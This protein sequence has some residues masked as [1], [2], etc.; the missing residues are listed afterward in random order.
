MARP[1]RPTMARRLCAAHG[2]PADRGQVVTI[3]SC[4]AGHPTTADQR[5]P[6]HAA[7]D[8]ARPPAGRL[9]GRRDRWLPRRRTRRATTHHRCGR[10]QR[11]R[12]D[13]VAA[14]SVRRIVGTDVGGEPR[15]QRQPGGVPGPSR[16]GDGSGRTGPMRVWF[17]VWRVDTDE[18]INATLDQLAAEHPNLHVVPWHDISAAASGVVQRHRRAPVH[19][20]LCRARSAGC[21]RR[22]P[23]VCGS[24]PD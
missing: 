18:S 3:R 24:G 22:Q 4:P 7:P 15:H 9:A 2:Q 13:G 14:G 6:K 1:G 21:R 10:R 20:R 11:E 8:H 17:D 23:R 16:G 12:H 19:R 5:C